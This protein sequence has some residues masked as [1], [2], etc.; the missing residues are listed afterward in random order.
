MTSRHRQE[1]F[2]ASLEQMRGSSGP[3]DTDGSASC[4]P[5]SVVLMRW[6]LWMR[7]PRKLSQGWMPQRS[8]WEEMLLQRRLQH[9]LRHSM[10]SCILIVELSFICN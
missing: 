6:R 8:L 10:P 3:S 7:R 1:Q 5:A 2:V 9:K 4:A